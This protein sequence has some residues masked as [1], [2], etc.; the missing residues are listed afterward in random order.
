MVNG[1]GWSAFKHANVETM[2]ELHTSGTA[3]QLQDENV[4]G[5]DQEIQHRKDE[6]EQLSPLVR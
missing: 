5:V 2:S 4:R 1:D 3:K 6:V